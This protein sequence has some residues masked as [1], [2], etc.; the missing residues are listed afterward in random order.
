VIEPIEIIN[1][2]QEINEAKPHLVNYDAIFWVLMGL[3]VLFIAIAKTLKPNYL[4]FLFITAVINRQLLQ[5]TQEELKLRSVTSILLT[6]TYFNCLA[7]VIS[8]LVDF[9]NGALI[10]LFLSIFLGAALLKLVLIKSMVFLTKVSEGSQEHIFNHFIFYQIAGVILSPILIITHFAPESIQTFV[11]VFSVSLLILL[12]IVR[13]IQSFFRAINIKVP[14]LYIILY[15][16]TLELLP[17]VL[18]I[19]ALVNNSNGLN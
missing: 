8:S 5:N 4:K 1:N 10:L 17:L 6:L 3:N 16:C 9:N 7:I 14:L 15:L 19:Y 13:E 18:I 11:I 12:I 2:V